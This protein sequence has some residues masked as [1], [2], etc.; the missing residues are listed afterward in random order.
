M[1]EYGNLGERWRNYLE[2]RGVSPE[3]AKW[4]GYRQVFS[5]NPGDAEKLGGGTEPADFAAHYGF[6]KNSGGLLIPL[7]P[8]IGD[9]I[10]AYQLRT[11]DGKRKFRTPKG[12]QNYI[13]GGAVGADAYH[14]GY[15]IAEGV[16]RV[17][18]LA[19]LAVPAVAIPG[20]YGWRGKSS[21]AIP[22]AKVTEDAEA[23]PRVPK[24]L[25]APD[26]DYD[27]NPYVKQAIDRLAAWLHKS[28]KAEYVGRIAL[29]TS[30]GLDD[31]VARR[32]A[33]GVETATIRAEIFG[34]VVEVGW[35]DA[36]RAAAAVVD[37]DGLSPELKKWREAE[38]IAIAH[39]NSDGAIDSDVGMAARHLSLYGDGVVLALDVTST[40]EDL[41]VYRLD[42]RGVM[43]P[44][45]QFLRQEVA[46]AGQYYRRKAVESN[47]NIS[48]DNWKILYHISTAHHSNGG[49][50]RAA[51]A[52]F[53]AAH[54]A[55]HEGLPPLHEIVDIK[56]INASQL[57][58][59]PRYIGAKNG[60]VDLQETRLLTRQEVIDAG[61]FVT[62]CLA[63]EYHPEAHDHEGGAHVVDKVFGT[64]GIAA[65]E[66][67]AYLGRAL[68]GAPPEASLL[69]HG[70]KNSAKS[71]LIGALQAVMGRGTGGAQMA[72]TSALDGSMFA[73]KHTDEL[74]PFTDASIVIMEEAQ[75]AQWARGGNAAKFK[76]MT[77]G[78]NV[79]FSLSRKAEKG[80]TVP[81]H[82]FLIAVGNRPPERMGLHDDAVKKRQRPVEVEPHGVVDGTIRAAFYEDSAAARCLLARMVQAAKE[83]PVGSART[84]NEDAMP[85][86]MKAWRDKLVEEST[87]P[88]AVW[89]RQV[90]V[91]SPGLNVHGTDIW[92]AWLK[93]DGWKPPEGFGDSEKVPEERNGLKRRAFF[94]QIANYIT[95][96]MGNQATV[97][98]KGASGNGFKDWSLDLSRLRVEEEQ[99]PGE[100]PYESP[101]RAADTQSEKDAKRARDEQI[102]ARADASDPNSEEWL[103]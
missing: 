71:T 102:R 74:A 49:Q 94:A 54:E 19:A 61:I 4:R 93:Q 56:V 2:L 1:S 25:L 95:P 59:Q 79:T 46:V 20:I 53:V 7:R 83:N 13:A 45:A 100:E 58:N 11:T 30:E 51:N 22:F 37:E 14:D 33:E 40:A 101:E 44:S 57:D 97:R 55:R 41:Y 70:P 99:E 24:Y 86:Y 8:I 28:Q 39:A 47:L 80:R 23:L 85:D 62:R 3:I 64:Y 67:M 63:S 60:V 78:P 16:T 68:Y 52:M 90:L 103:D 12:Q 96:P 91:R 50:E 26:G 66:V 77:G 43:V 29:P 18:A 84:D 48:P 75:D 27:T 38:I 21:K 5:G 65:D 69:I 6:P 15:I 92:V 9:D 35:V 10:P 34:M 98:V 72:D 31:Y 42:E 82:G 76:R 17:D 73:S 36:T 87:P 88:H 32:M 81:L 89:A